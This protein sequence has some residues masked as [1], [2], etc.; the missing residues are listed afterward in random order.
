M[1]GAGDDERYGVGRGWSRMGLVG[2]PV[3]VGR[4]AYEAAQR[5]GRRGA[6]RSGFGRLTVSLRFPTFP[7]C[8]AGDQARRRA[9]RRGVKGEDALWRRPLPRFF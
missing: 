3:R 9:T 1:R 8:A 2:G 7:W 4:L 5:P 6:D